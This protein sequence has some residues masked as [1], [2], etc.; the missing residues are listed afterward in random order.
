M[1]YNFPRLYCFE[2]G[3]WDLFVWREHATAFGQL[4][5]P[6]ALLHLVVPLLTVPQAPSVS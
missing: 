6:E 5:L 3:L 1:A 2:E 4:A